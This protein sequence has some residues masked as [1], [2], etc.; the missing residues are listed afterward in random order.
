[1]LQWI[2][3]PTSARRLAPTILVALVV[4]LDSP[5][6]CG[7]EGSADPV[8][9]KWLGSASTPVEQVVVGVEF[10]R[11][12]T[13]ELEPFFTLPVA[14]YFGIPIP[15]PVERDGDSVAVGM[16]GMALKLSNGRL[17]GTFPF[18]ASPVTLERVEALPT[19]PAIPE[20]PVPPEPRWLAQLG[21]RI[22]ASPTVAEGITYVGTT[23]GVMYAVDAANGELIWAFRAGRPILGAA[24]AEGSALFFVCDDGNLYKVSR[25]KGEEIWRYD[26]GDGLTPR[27]LPAPNAPGWDCQAPT[28]VVADGVVFVG[29][30]AGTF[31]AVDVATGEGRWR[32][33]AEG[34]IRNGAAIDESRVLF[35]AADRHL[36]A[37]E[38]ATGQLVW[39]HDTGAPIDSSP[40]VVDGRVLIGNR[41][42][43]LLALGAETGER[44]WETTFWGSWV[45]ATPVIFE[46]VAYIGSSDLR[47]VS[48]IAPT[49]GRV[50]WRTDVFGWSWGTPLVTDKRI[51]VCAAGGNAHLASFNVL[52]RATGR[53]LQRRPH[54]EATRGFPWGFGGSPV[55]S[56]D[57]IVAATIE[58]TLYGFP[59][60]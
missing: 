24:L 21:G 9:G 26:L 41:G 58:G 51:Y 33:V 55:L 19:A 15:A 32:F 40:V 50:L 34:K 31:H 10:R 44:Q 25:D 16:L 59:L 39:K 2:A 18:P 5:L 37:L 36:Y 49:D 23:S 38:R 14:N 12:E 11:S 53:L 46:G 47:R 42:A 60:Q 48:A 22:F 6:E 4:W 27:I 45:E 28:P 57:T 54:G 43:G 3:S 8:E 56:G 30:G 20:L 35:G 13:G 7:A 17:E 52:D 1:M 29:S